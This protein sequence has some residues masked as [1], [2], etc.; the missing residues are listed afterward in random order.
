MANDKYAT[1]SSNPQFTDP[2]L[3]RFF[4]TS[5]D[6]EN[7]ENGRLILKSFYSQQTSNQ[8]NL[9]FFYGRKNRFM[10][11]LLWAKGSQDMREFLDYMNVESSNK[12]YTK[13]D[14]TQQ[15]IATQFVNTLVESM[16]KNS[17]YPSVNAVDD[18]SLNEKEQR[19]FDALYRMYEQKNIQDLQQQAGMQLEPPNAYIPDD[20]ISAKV[21]FELEDRLPKEIRFEELI[22]KTREDVRFER[23]LN[24]KGLKD[25]VVT[26]FEAT[27]IEKK[28][29]HE[30]TVR[31]CIPTN[32]VYNFFMNDTGEC[33]VTMVG[34]FYGLKVK[35]F[36][37]NFGKSETNPNGLTEEEIF[38]L[39]KTSTNKNI[40]TFN[41]VWMPTWGFSTYNQNRPYDDCQILVM[42]CEI[43][44]G[45]D[46]YYVTKVDA[47]GKDVIQQKKNIPYQQVTKDGKVIPQEKPDNVTITKG[48]K[49]TWMRGVYAPDSD[50]MLYWGRPD[51]II[52]PYTNT[53]KSLSSYSLVIPNNDGDYVPSLFERIIEPLKEYS[54]LK[55]QRKKLIAKIR[56]MGIRIDVESARNLD[57]G[58][59][60]SIAWE[61]VLRI[62][63]QTGSEVWSSKG[64]NP[65][66]Q[67][68]PAIT[69]VPQDPTVSKIL[70]ITQVLN[71]IV[72]EMRMLI[73]TSVYLEGGDL[74]DRTAA[75]LAEGQVDQAPN[76]F[77]YVLNAHNSVWEE[78]W[79]KLCLLH[80]N[81]IVRT[82]PESKD[83]ML[84]TRF[85]IEI[86]MKST[87]E[88]KMLLE[89][90]IQRYSQVVDA[91]GNPALT[92]KDAMMLREINDAKLA[93]WYMVDTMQKNKREAEERSMRLQQQN[94]NVQ[95]Q[96]MV[97]AQEAKNKAAED[98]LLIQ[99]K[100]SQAE[101]REKKEEIFLQ[102]CATIRSKGLPIPPEW[103]S[104]EK[105]LLQNIQAALF[106]ENKQT[107][108]AV[109]NG[110]QQAQ[111]EQQEQAES[112]QQQQ[113]EAQ[114]GL[115]QPT[116]QQEQPQM[117]S[118]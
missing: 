52:C 40:G 114:Q 6:R 56:P 92:P 9:N 60:D 32:M 106:I 37:K 66:E 7:K 13:I 112:Q 58:N 57:L 55:L 88:E 59:G 118:Q 44:C 78:T 15:R 115:E 103:A 79:Y 27:K 117:Q 104:V 17:T 62:F 74:G 31:K 64:V 109:D 89:Q 38:N 105:E 16:A 2:L 61:E 69:N 24:R 98:D 4:Q 49:T 110:I 26:N 48:T 84:N 85:D 43:D 86:K 54:L 23:V 73:G 95:Q 87:V 1:P 22:R 28:G 10:E 90:D 34:E 12:A 39:A 93:R 71:S 47:F 81:D 102:G 14:Y 51:L 36:R 96:S 25:L 5:A 8:T 50:V 70:E 53:N 19:M 111:Q 101:G 68:T 75:K 82:E 99:V 46:V 30:Y 72:N 77:G 3:N 76:V 18:G 41:Y 100:K 45:E 67:A 97:A 80:W 83:D 20:E 29:I 108:M 94:A 42:D 35:D 33:E 113:Q 116:E 11:L 91:E 21:Y 65:L 107:E 63:D